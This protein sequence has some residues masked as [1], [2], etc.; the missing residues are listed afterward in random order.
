MMK[1]MDPLCRGLYCALNKINM[2][3]TGVKISTCVFLSKKVQKAAETFSSDLSHDLVE[4]GLSLRNEGPQKGPPNP[5]MS[6][7]LS[8]SVNAMMQRRKRLSI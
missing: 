5:Q 3:S 8:S 1:S 4:R 6:A 7:L 2:A